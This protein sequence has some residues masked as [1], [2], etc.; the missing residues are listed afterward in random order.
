MGKKKKR[1]KKRFEGVTAVICTR[2]KGALINRVR[3]EILRVIAKSLSKEEIDGG[4]KKYGFISVMNE[5][6][7]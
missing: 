2:R 6:F 3:R 7:S 4:E 5:A 1:G